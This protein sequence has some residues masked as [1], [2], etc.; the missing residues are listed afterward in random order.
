MASYGENYSHQFGAAFQTHIL[1]VIARTPTFALR[2]RT[3]LH[4]DFFEAQDHRVLAKVLLGYVDQYDSLPTET[5]LLECL[6]EQTSKD[7]FAS[8]GPTVGGL[9]QE[10]ISDADAVMDRVIEFGQNQAMVNAVIRGA[11][12]LETGNRDI[13]PLIDEAL[14]VGQDLLDLG[15]NYTKDAE[16]RFNW[17]LHPE[18]QSK[19]VVPTGIT[20]M[21]Q[22]MRG[23]LGRG[24][25]G[26]VLA[27]PK[28]G[29][30]TLLI[31]IGYGALLDPRALN[32]VHFTLE[33]SKQKV[34][35]R[36]DDRLMGKLT[37]TRSTDPQKYVEELRE[38]V[39][40]LVRG[41]LFIK[42][43][44]TR[45]A[46]V[47]DMRSY[48]TILSSQG[49]K[50]DCVIVDYADIVKPG[51]RLGEMRHEQ[52]GI[53]EDLRAMAG[54]F[55]VVVW[56][57]SQANR[58]SLD[59]EV[60]TIQD[61]AESFEK[62]AIVDAAWAFCQTLDERMD[63]ECRLFGA[64]LRGV[65]DGVT[66]VCHIDRDSCLI[67]SRE[68]LDAAYANI[69]NDPAKGQSSGEV[70]PKVS[71]GTPE[72]DLRNQ[73]RATSVKKVTKKRA[74]KKVRRG[75]GAETSGNRIEWGDD[76]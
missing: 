66:A 64:A 50:P 75:K 71:G 31:N 8:L 4:P 28:R 48:L 72:S 5:T 40:T 37:K 60:I 44:A 34:A 38:R 67:E 11:E 46:T 45:Q 19:N 15:H 70:E 74:K 14:L 63:F 61:F 47:A 30:T 24:E 27:P 62:S 51:R 2:Y 68:L 29:K 32:V 3:V 17:Y 16:D 10:D 12:R 22:A 33:M 26:V 41:Q 23:G 76:G 39:N 13:R 59:K 52:A 56:A 58:G 42:E 7:Q 36:Y 1:A 55:D 20:H 35:R 69:S 43:Y 9:Y 6:K 18:E 73:L 54:E 25:M 57:A 65:E 53:Y 49:F 21:D